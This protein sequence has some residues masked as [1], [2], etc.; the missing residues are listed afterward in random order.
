MV[1][2]LIATLSMMSQTKVYVYENDGSYTEFEMAKFDSLSFMVPESK[3]K[4]NASDYAQITIGSQTW[5]AENYHCSKYDTN[6][7]A[8]KSGMYA[9]PA[10]SGAMYAPYYTDATN[11]TKYDWSVN[12]GEFSQDLTDEQISKLGYL[13]N[14]AAAVGVV[15]GKKQT[16]DFSGKRQGI[17]PNGWHM[18]TKAE[19]ETLVTFVG[20]ENIAG[21]RLKAASGWYD[22]EDKSSTDDYGFT[23]LPAGVS[24]RSCVTQV[25]Y[26]TML[27]SATQSTDGNGRKATPLYVEYEQDNIRMQT[28]H[29]DKCIGGSIRCLKD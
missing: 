22:W 6:S 26:L 5:M 16:S 8:Y 19:F 28:W 21:K 11:T 24:H 14:W 3:E 1:V 12:A 20:G 10:I 18:P 23:A 17:C 25:G 15:D 7:E 2:S 27:W 29:N 4:C 13:Y 9:V